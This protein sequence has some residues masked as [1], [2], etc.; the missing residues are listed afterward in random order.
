MT[1]GSLWEFIRRAAIRNFEA[2]LYFKQ[3]AQNVELPIGYNKYTFPTVDAKDGAAAALTEWTVPTEGSFNL[4][5]VEVTLTQ[6]GSFVK[7][8]DVVLTDSPVAAIE[9][10]S[11]ELGR[12]LANKVDAVIQDTVDAGTNV[13]YV[14]QTSRAAITATDTIT[15]ATIAEAVNKLKANDAPTFDGN[16]YIAVLHPFVYHDLQVEG[17]TGSF[18]DVNK[19]FKQENIMNG[20]IG[21]LYGTRI[22]ISSNVQFYVDAGAASTVDVYPSYVVGRNAYGVVMSGGLQT[23]VNGIGS[24]SDLNI[25]SISGFFLQQVICHLSATPAWHQHRTKRWPHPW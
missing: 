24:W 3:I 19:Y 9:E 13:I 4:T 16:S 8:S 1:S 18:I 23:F 20:E 14:G 11:F 22:V 12:D 17:N 2:S 21:M 7:L 6:Y 10:A 25:S 5:N 15:A